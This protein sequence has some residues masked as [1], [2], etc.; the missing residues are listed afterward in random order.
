MA[1]EA[2]RVLEICRRLVTAPNRV[3][4]TDFVVLAAFKHARL[5]YHL[6]TK[7]VT[8]SG[9]GLCMLQSA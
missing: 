8:E 4:F 6:T 7:F 2:A 9:Y 1:V 3:N 5:L